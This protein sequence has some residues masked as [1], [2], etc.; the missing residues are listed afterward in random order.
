MERLIFT[1]PAVTLGELVFVAVAV[2]LV[3]FIPLLIGWVN[4]RAASALAQ[5]SIEP[6]IGATTK[7]TEMPPVAWQAAPE[8]PPLEWPVS[9][10]APSLDPWHPD[11]D[12]AAYGT[13]SELP[14]RFQP[15]NVAMQENNQANAP[16]PSLPPPLGAIRDWLAPS[17]QYTSLPAVFVSE[18]E[19]ANT[20]L[21]DLRHVTLATWPGVARA[22][23]AEVHE[24]WERGLRLY[25]RWKS[26]LLSL[27][28]PLPAESR[29][30]TLARIETDG[31]LF[32]FH[33]LVFDQLWPTQLDEALAVCVIDV[34]P[35]QG[36]VSWC[37][38][39]PVVTA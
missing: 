35:E 30:Y 22:W 27:S 23:P 3:L 8:S 15:A 20:R 38:V 26:S 36:P 16:Q 13:T 19:G 24:L 37:V 39:P 5:P 32:R 33:I 29:S 28:L 34:R 25:E 2:V 9:P 12:V 31:S 11:E 18:S 14:A 1:A 6:E 21:E 7:G 17:G 10:P 4:A